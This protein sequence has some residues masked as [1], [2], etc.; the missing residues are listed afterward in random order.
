MKFTP[1]DYQR[2]I[3]NFIGDRLDEHPGCAVF[4]DPGTGKTAST[5]HAIEIGMLLG[6]FT[7]VLIVGPLRVI[8][9]VWPDEIKKWGFPFSHEILHGTVKERETAMAKPADLHL[10]NHDGIK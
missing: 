7:R 4:A 8:H 6:D 1:H 10:I 3:S 5:L 2:E 9:L